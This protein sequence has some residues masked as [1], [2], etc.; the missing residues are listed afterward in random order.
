[1]DGARIAIAQG[2]GRSAGQLVARTD[3]EWG[4]AVISVTGGVGDRVVGVADHAAHLEALT[5]AATALIAAEGAYG[6]GIQGAITEEN[7]KSQCGAPP[8][9]RSSRRCLTARPSLRC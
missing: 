8:E 2:N 4:G 9:Y 3:G 7:S 6:P 1:V 5:L